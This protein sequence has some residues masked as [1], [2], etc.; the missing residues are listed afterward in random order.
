MSR[1]RGSMAVMGVPP[2]SL[3]ASTGA[4]SGSA[5]REI[6]SVIMRDWTGTTHR[7]G[8][9]LGWWQ[10]ENAG[11]YGATRKL[12]EFPREGLRGLKLLA[13]FR[14]SVMQEPFCARLPGLLKRCGLGR[15]FVTR[16]GRNRRS[17]ARA[18]WTDLS[19]DR[20]L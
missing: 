8:R 2:L 3:T 12:R 6:S 20:A 4:R 9:D 18:P 1:M 11:I 19:I 5:Q 7:V 14:R 16:H 15:A 13:H 10:L 17:S